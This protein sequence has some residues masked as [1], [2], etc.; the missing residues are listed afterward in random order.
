MG[1]TQCHAVM[2]CHPH[3]QVFPCLPRQGGG[4]KTSFVNKHKQFT[5]YNYPSFTFT[6]FCKQRIR[7]GLGTFG[8]ERENDT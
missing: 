3:P 1:V 2:L 5:K 6:S 8:Y 7:A 4:L